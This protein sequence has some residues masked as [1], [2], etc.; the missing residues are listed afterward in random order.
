MLLAAGIHPKVVSEQLGH[1]GIGITLDTYQ[2]MMPN[3]QCEAA[4]TLE[5]RLFGVG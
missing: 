3:V 4:E 2:H 1:N 5:R